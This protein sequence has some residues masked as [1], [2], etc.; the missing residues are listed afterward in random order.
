MVRSMKMPSV[1]TLGVELGED[2]V[3]LLADLGAFFVF[4]L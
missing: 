4:V 3:A 1:G 2:F